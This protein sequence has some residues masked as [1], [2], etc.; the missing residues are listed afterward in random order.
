MLGCYEIAKVPCSAVSHINILIYWDSQW[1][2]LKEELLTW[3]INQ[4]ISAFSRVCYVGTK[5]EGG[6]PTDFVCL[7]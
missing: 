4:D 5:T 1:R 7:R 6:R 2:I 3:L